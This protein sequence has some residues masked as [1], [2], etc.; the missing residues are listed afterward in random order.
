MRA[1]AT[2]AGSNA[3]DDRLPDTSATAVEKLET[4]GMVVLGR[5]HMVE[6]AYGG[7]GTQSRPGRTAQSRGDGRAIACRRLQQRFGR[8]RRRRAGTG[9]ARD[10][11]RRLHQDTGRLVRHRR[12]EDF[13][14]PRRPRRRRSA[15][16]RP[17]IVSVRWRALF[18]M[19]PSCSQ[20]MMRRRPPRRCHPTVA[21]VRPLDDIEDGVEDFRIGV[22]PERDLEGVEPELRTLHDRAIAELRALGASFSEI[23]LPAVDQPVSRQRRR[24]HECGELCAA[25][26]LRRR[27]PTARSIR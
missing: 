15:L 5:T 26:R 12:P 20:A 9:R 2:R 13:S 6:F 17:T 11:H 3:L 25:R 7:W 8:R 16:P 14:R 23:A 1:I 22:L 21:L 18:A 19:R 27:G 10:G 24:Y 4:G